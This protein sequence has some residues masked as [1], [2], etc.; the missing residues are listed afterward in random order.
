MF[1]GLLTSMVSA[2]NHTKQVL[3]SNQKCIIQPTFTNLHPSEYSQELHYYPFS[4]NLDRCVGSFN[5]VNGLSNKVFVPY[6]TEDL[7][8]SVFT[9][10]TGIYKS[11]TLTKYTSCKCKCKFNGVIQSVLKIKQ[12]IMINVY[13]SAKNIIHV[14]KFI[15][16]ILL[17]VIAK[18]VNIWQ[19][20]LTSQ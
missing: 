12:R 1:I 3:L 7:N 8:L 13:V 10:I 18:L 14:K 5:I 20:L 19:V 6:K 17:H 4:D 9:M 2:S 15:F 11:K 16:E